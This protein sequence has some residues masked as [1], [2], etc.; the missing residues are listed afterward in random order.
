MS[1][2]DNTVVQFHYTLREDD[3]LIE[4]SAGNEPLAYL[5]GHGNIIPGLEK[6]M[7]GKS[8]GDE[9]EVTVPCSEGYGERQ[10]DKTQQIPVK[11]LHGSKKWKPGMVANVRTD[12][13]VRQ[14]TIVK[15]G[16]KHATV[17]L[18]HPL[19]GKELTFSV[20]IVDT[21]DATEE[22]VAHGHAHGVGGHHH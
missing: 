1:I 15:A 9:F 12:H 20:Q 13:G 10:E 4:T 18:N 19:A 11:H 17:D 2:A 5:H 7:L 6:A 3:T 21:R 16:L 22:E 14:V 8:A